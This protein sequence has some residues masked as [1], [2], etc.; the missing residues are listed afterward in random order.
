MHTGLMIDDMQKSDGTT[1]MAG[2]SPR[3]VSDV[4]TR[5]RLQNET[6]EKRVPTITRTDNLQLPL[7][8]DFSRTSAGTVECGR[9]ETIT[10]SALS[11]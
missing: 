11:P 5:H 10:C 7:S 3:L 2:Y 6:D 1:E 8:L 4:I 9:R